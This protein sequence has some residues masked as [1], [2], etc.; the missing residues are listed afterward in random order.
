MQFAAGTF[1]NG[2]YAF[3][4]DITIWNEKPEWKFRLYKDA[5]APNIWEGTFEDLVAVLVAAS[6]ARRQ[7]AS[8]LSVMSQVNLDAGIGKEQHD[9]I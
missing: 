4:G 1:R 2:E 5:L 8:R 6:P 9:K 7:V 3:A